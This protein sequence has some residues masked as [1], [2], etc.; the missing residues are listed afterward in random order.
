MAKKV[1]YGLWDSPITPRDTAGQLRL[2]DVAWAGDGETLVWVEGRG[3]QGVVAARMGGNAERVISGDV[4]VGGG[5]GY[6]GGEL[7]VHEQTAFFA[8]RDGR[9]WRSEIA[10]G[11]PRPIT[12]KHGAVAS[13]TVSPDGR[14]VVYVHTDGESDVLAAVDSEGRQWPWKI[15]VGADFYMQPTWSPEGDRLA[16]ISWDQPQMPWDGTRLESAAVEHD[17]RG[18]KLGPVEVWAGDPNTAIANPI[19]APDGDWLAYT[20]DQLGFNQLWIRELETTDAVHLG[21]QEADLGGPAWIQGLRSMVWETDETLIG[22]LNERGFVRLV[23]FSL[24]TREW[25]PIPAATVYTAVSQPTVSARGHIAFIG[26]ASIVPPRVVNL[27]DG[28]APRVERRAT[29]ERVAI[30]R[31]SRMQPVSWTTDDGGPPVEVFANYY[32]PTNPDYE[33]IGRPPAIV[34]IHGGPTSQ[35][36]ACWDA[37]AQFFAT[38]GFAVLDVN[39]RGSTGYGRTYMEMLRGEWGLLDVED[40][41][42]GQKFLIDSD[43]AHPDKVVIMGGSAGGYTVL[44]ALCDY[45]GAFAGGVCLYGIGNLFSLAM[46]THKFEAAYNDVLIGPLPEAAS[47]FRERSPVFKS[48]RIV[49]PVAIFHGAKDKAVPPDQATEIVA[50]LRSRGVPH[51]FHMYDNEGHGFRH[52]ENIEHFYEATLKFL[53]EHVLYD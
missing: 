31:L 46:S 7:A 32:P 17:A 24:D 39:Y 30:E 14:W 28:D 2:M 43:L 8:G 35:R 10:A 53:R 44:Q 25:E 52:P 16:W 15:V 29:N 40:A 34:R 5:V 23:R 12:P 26:S 38:R 49:D 48:E 19:F 20:S 22:T 6:G 1:P 11:Q 18:F 47:K 45:P 41:I 51:L 36:T 13:P 21:R 37:Q 27:I 3:A 42:A 4:N 9:I 33:A 50:S